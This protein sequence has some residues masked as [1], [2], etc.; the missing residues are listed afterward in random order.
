MKHR[1]LFRTTRSPGQSVTLVDNRGSG[2]TMQVWEH[3]DEKVRASVAIGWGDPIVLV[4]DHTVGTIREAE[5]VT[6]ATERVADDR[7]GFYA[8]MA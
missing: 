8:L 5:A 1:M 4:A 7:P 2:I 3:C 6:W